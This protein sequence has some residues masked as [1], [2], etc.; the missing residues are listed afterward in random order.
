LKCKVIQS[1]HFKKDLKKIDKSMY[2]IIKE[3]KKE[4]STRPEIGEPLK[5]RLKN[6]RKVQIGKYRMG[7]VFTPCEVRILLIKHRETV[8]ER[9]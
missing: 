2:K 5:G 8:Y 4:L 6:V 9:Y 1:K 7:Y 3:R